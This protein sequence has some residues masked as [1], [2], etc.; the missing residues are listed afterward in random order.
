MGIA[1]KKTHTKF[2]DLILKIGSASNFKIRAILQ[3]KLP[4]NGHFFSHFFVLA[5]NSVGWIFLKPFSLVI[6]IS[7]IFSRNIHKGQTYSHNC[8]SHNTHNDHFGHDGCFG[9]TTYSHNAGIS[10]NGQRVQRDLLVS[11]WIYMVSIWTNK[12]M[13]INKSISKFTSRIYYQ[14]SLLSLQKF[15]IKKLTIDRFQ[16]KNS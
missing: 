8:S 10:S 13:K 11:W 2:E 4:E 15:H 1:I 3:R 5:I 14:I 12:S 9:S 16:N 7:S 6:Y